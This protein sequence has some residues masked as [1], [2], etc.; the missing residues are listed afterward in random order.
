MGDQWHLAQ[1]TCSQTEREVTLAILDQ[2]M[3]RAGI[4][5]RIVPGTR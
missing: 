1:R 2:R 5:S 4:G 3:A